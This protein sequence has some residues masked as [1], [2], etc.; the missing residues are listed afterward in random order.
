VAELAV[1]GF[2]DTTTADQV[3]P[4]L[5]ALQ[6]EG[7]L[8]LEDWARVIRRPDGSIDTR[9]MTNT[10]GV[11]AAGGALWGLLFGLL[12]FIPLAG[13]LL[14]AGMG[15]I[16]GRLA[17]IG[18]D[19]KFIKEVGQQITPGTSALFLYVRESTTDRVIERLSRFQPT[20]IRSS[21]SKEAEAQLRAAIEQASQ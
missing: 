8:Q 14:G 20:L 17:D 11:G 16:F 15:A 21:L 9:Q 4:E 6:R 5:E 1:L 3:I 7:L 2:K 10:T 18:I 12:F 19:D 13:A